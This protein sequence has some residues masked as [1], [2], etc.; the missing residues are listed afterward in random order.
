MDTLN[1]NPG[2]PGWGLCER[3][4]TSPRK[5]IITHKLQINDSRTDS[6]KTTN[7]RKKDKR[8]GIQDMIKI[9]TWNVR[10]I[11]NKIDELE[12]E[13]KDKNIDLAIIT[14]T[15]KKQKGSSDLKEYSMFYSGVNIT[16]KARAGVAV[17]I[18]AKFKKALMNGQM[19]E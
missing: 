17:L 18:N 19:K 8:L 7:A 16:E 13:L 2:P 9:A 5:T 12:E 14:E 11:H 6:W 4:V 15:K 3:L 1:T 10:G